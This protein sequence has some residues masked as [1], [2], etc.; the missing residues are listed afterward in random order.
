MS[1]K[2]QNAPTVWH[3]SLFFSVLWFVAFCAPTVRADGLP[4]KWVEVRTPHFIVASNASQRSA[5]EIA[6]QFEQIRTLFSRALPVPVPELGPP[7]RILAVDGERTMKVLLPERWEQRGR[8]RPAGLFQRTPLG[9]FVVVQA[10]LLGREDYGI[11]YHEYFHLLADSTGLRL[12]VWVSEGLASF[13]G[14]TRLTSKVAEVGRPDG[15]YIGYLR[16]GQLLPLEAL[17]TVDRSSPHYNRSEKAHRFYAQSWALI[18]YILLGDKTGKARE[19]FGEYSRLLLAGESSEKAAVQAFGDLAKLE[20]KL[21]AYVRRLLFRYIKLPPPAPPALE[22]FQVRKLPSEEAAARVALFRLESR[23]TSGVQEFVDLATKSASGLPEASLALGLFN[24]EL[25]KYTEAEEAFQ[26]AIQLNDASPVARYGAAVMM[27][28]ADPSAP[29]LRAI[30][31]HLVRAIELDPGFSP[32]RIRLAEVYR[33]EDGCSQRALAQ[34]RAARVLVPNSLSFRLKEAQLLLGC[35]KA[36]EAR[37]IVREVVEEVVETESASQ[38]NSLCWDGS[39]WGFAK[40][41]LPACERAVALR[42]ESFGLLDSR[43]V[44]RAI[45]GDV[46]GA[47]AD[48]ETALKLAG[49]D[50]WDEETKHQRSTWLRALKTGENPFA[51]DGLA[52][53]R[54][55]PKVAGLGWMK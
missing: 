19:Q 30:E 6:E 27:F 7:L 13:W 39:L 38:S 45:S 53:M 33:R 46:Q 40:E 37:E 4:G 34:S 32:A 18:H 10:D 3:Y 50:G 16:G 41:V 28:Y 23:S 20:S 15:T 36:Q 54:D 29:R 44:A 24:L 48:F 12:P 43:A 25:G 31:E 51:E 5:Q 22:D 26:R 9:T 2:Q 55:D 35:E 52:R 49:E 42:P 14:S 21:R 47:A 8:S 11:V 1:W 17:M